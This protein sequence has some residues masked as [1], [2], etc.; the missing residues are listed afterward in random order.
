[1]EVDE[2]KMLACCAQRFDAPAFATDHP[3]FNQQKALDAHFRKGKWPD[4][5]EEK[6]AI[7]YFLQLCASDTRDS[8]YWRAY[9]ELF[10]ELYQ[11]DVPA[12]YMR[13]EFVQQWRYEYGPMLSA[14]VGIVRETHK[15]TQY[16]ESTLPAEPDI[17][18]AESTE[19]KRSDTWFGS[20]FSRRT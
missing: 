18:E 15:N 9:R 5:L 4:K 19:R 7:F 17:I 2:L 11:R 12:Q 8:P 10:L 13:E 14:Y 3:Q 6:L 1:M 16:R 20:L